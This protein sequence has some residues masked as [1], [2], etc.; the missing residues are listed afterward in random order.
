METAAPAGGIP[1]V[2]Q[3]PPPTKTKYVV[4]IE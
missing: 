3:Y 4:I 2:E 1:S